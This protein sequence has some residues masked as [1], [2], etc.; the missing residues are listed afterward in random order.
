MT[1]SLH[2]TISNTDFAVRN[3][4]PESCPN[5]SSFIPAGTKLGRFGKLGTKLERFGQLG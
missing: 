4:P 2:D 1:M 3:I 5:R